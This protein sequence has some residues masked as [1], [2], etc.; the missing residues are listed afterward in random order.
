MRID[1]GRR[2]NKKLYL[3]EETE[4]SSFANQ[5]RGITFRVKAI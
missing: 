2:E 4:L 1:A 5:I 3:F